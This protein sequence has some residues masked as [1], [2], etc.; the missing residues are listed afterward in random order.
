VIASWWFQANAASKKEEEALPIFSPALLL[1][2]GL[3]L[4]TNIHAVA[5]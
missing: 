1:S 3:S 2:C 5:H 4:S